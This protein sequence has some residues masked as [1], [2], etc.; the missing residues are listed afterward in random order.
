MF[1]QWK[2]FNAL[3]Q[4]LEM[5]LVKTD[6]IIGREYAALCADANWGLELFQLIEDE[7]RRSCEHVRAITGSDELLGS[8]PALRRSLLLRNPYLDPISFIQ[9]K[10][11]REYRRDDLSSDQRERILRLLRST[12][13]GIAAGLRNTG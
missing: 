12:V 6:M 13:N 1:R 4:N 2:F 10:F 9:I 8:N 3:V 5:V 11:I 7:F